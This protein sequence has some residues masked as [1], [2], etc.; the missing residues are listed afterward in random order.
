MARRGGGDDDIEPRRERARAAPLT[1][2]HRPMISGCRGHT[3]ASYDPRLRVHQEITLPNED[4]AAGA[5]DIVEVVNSTIY[6]F[7]DGSRSWDRR[8][9]TA[10]STWPTA[11]TAATHG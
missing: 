2:S 3:Q 11:T 7:Q 8:T 10:S 6:V 1:A 9:S 5:T 4:V